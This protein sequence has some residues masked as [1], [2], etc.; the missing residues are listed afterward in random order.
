MPETLKNLR[1]KIKQNSKQRHVFYITPDA[2]KAEGGERIISNYSV[3]TFRDSPLLMNIRAHGADTFALDSALE[4]EELSEHETK[5]SLDLIR[6]KIVID[7]IESVLSSSGFPGCFLTLKNTEYLEEEINKKGWLLL[8]PK[9]S[10]ASQFEE[11][12]SQYELLK[13]AVPF[14]KT[15]LTLLRD[16]KLETLPVIVQFNRGFSG[17]STILVTDQNQF[18]DIQKKFPNRPARVSSYINGNT[19]TLNGLVL[20]SGQVIHGSISLQLT[21]LKE[22]TNNPNA[23]VGNDYGAAEEKLSQKEAE[24]IGRIIQRVGTELSRHGYHGMFGIDV[25]KEHASNNVF[26]IEINTHQP[27][28]ISFEYFLHEK[29]SR[30]S[31]LE[32]FYADALGIEVDSSLLNVPLF[33]HQKARQ[34]IYRNM[35]EYTIKASEVRLPAAPK[36][37]RVLAPRTG[38]IKPN[39]ESFRIQEFEY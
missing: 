5:G 3:I 18:D 20:K 34:I 27:A 10:V 15:Q 13:N 28:S 39:Q 4:G 31:I 6:S 19:Y 1:G 35:S 2:E 30:L 17:N 36:N 25:I 14:P 21:G 33:L 23:T 9:G 37:G 16:V 29:A 7:H 32:A 24:E 22:A 8:G 12:I 26:F 38:M 11:K